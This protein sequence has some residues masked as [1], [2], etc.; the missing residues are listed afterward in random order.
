M[1]LWFFDELELLLLE[2]NVTLELVCKA[3]ESLFLI[4]EMLG[5]RRPVAVQLKVTLAPISML[6][7]RG[8]SSNSGAR[9]VGKKYIA[10]NIPFYH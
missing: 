1:V 2:L 7:F 4:H 8:T 6:W 9:P 3:D 5:L 10:I